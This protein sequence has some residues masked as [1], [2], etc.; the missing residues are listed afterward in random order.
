MSPSELLS[1]N[2]IS[3][4]TCRLLSSTFSHGLAAT[5]LAISQYLPQILL[6]WQEGFI[7]SLSIPTMVIQVPGSVAFVISIAIREG[8]SWS[9]ELSNRGFIPRTLSPL[10]L[11]RF[12][13][14]HSSASSSLVPVRVHWLPPGWPLGAFFRS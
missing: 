2:L 8:T 13:P 4:L 11:T 5:I 7:G 12:L 3:W 6:T 1:I 10:T 14:P 9:C